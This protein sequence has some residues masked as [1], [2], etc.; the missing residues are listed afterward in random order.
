MLLLFLL[1]GLF[2]RA[3]SDGGNTDMRI[4]QFEKYIQ[5]FRLEDEI[6]KEEYLYRLNIFTNNV[7]HIES[8]NDQKKNTVELGITKFTHWSQ[9][10]FE[11]WV[12][13][14]VRSFPM[15]TSPLSPSTSHHHDRYIDEYPDSLDWNELGAVTPVKNQGRCGDCWS[16][17]VTGAMEGAYF[18]KYGKLPTSYDPNTG[19]TG[20]SEMQLTSCDMLSF[21]C[22]GGYPVSGYIYA[23]QNGGLTGESSYPFT[24]V[25]FTTGY[26]GGPNETC[27]H[28]DTENI[29]GT[30][31]DPANPYFV[32]EPTVD[33]FMSAIQVQPLSIQ[34]AASKN[35]FQF[36]KSGVIKNADKYGQKLP[37]KDQ[38]GDKLDHAV[39][40]VGYGSQDGVDYWKVKN[41]W[42]DTWGDLGGYVLI[43]RSSENVCGVLTGGTYPN[44]LTSA[45]T[46]TLM[47]TVLKFPMHDKL[48]VLDTKLDEKSLV[49]LNFEP[50]FPKEVL[51]RSAKF[52][53]NGIFMGS[54][55]EAI[56]CLSTVYRQTD[57]VITWVLG[58][59]SGSSSFAVHVAI[60]RDPPS[61]R[62]PDPLIGA[63]IRSKPFMV[64]GYNVDMSC[65]TLSQYEQTNANPQNL[66]VTMKHDDLEVYGLEYYI[67]KGR[68]NRIDKDN[69]DTTFT[70]SE[71]VPE[72]SI[73]KVFCIFALVITYVI[74]HS[75]C[76][77]RNFYKVGRG[78]S[79]QYIGIEMNDLEEKEAGA[80]FQVRED[81]VS[82]QYGSY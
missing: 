65:E 60:R 20:L 55:V 79:S 63:I 61:Y 16:F 58:A 44:L 23:A 40:L 30:A 59:V 17:S 31:T 1:L 64:P 53:G 72:E 38:C 82:C 15:N 47:P 14:G 67:I 66:T 56:A 71:N 3:F 32:V 49:G 18:I 69:F 33:A 2:C 42:S 24:A 54:D 81:V 48:Y 21:G 11:S 37:K 7:D 41:S 46:P 8:F 28:H 34:I 52:S 26:V 76:F 74:L 29:E 45:D 9:E 57:E 62:T 27:Y 22:N 6:S 78:R 10:E 70:D 43:E 68:I 51:L 25:N 39:L 73:Q 5:E 35:I 50:D 12:Q 77:L 80:L 19:F 36:Y 13:R 4:A 75:V